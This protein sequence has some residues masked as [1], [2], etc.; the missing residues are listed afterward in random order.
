MEEKPRF[1]AVD[2]AIRRRGTYIVFLTRL[3]PLFPFPLLNY[4]FGA[5]QIKFYQY[6]IGTV[7][8]AMPATIGYTYLGTLMRNVAELWT[9]ASTN[10]KWYLWLIGG[11]IT[12]ISIVVISFIT[13]RE[14]SRATK[15]YSEQVD[16]MDEA[17]MKLIN[18]PSSVDSV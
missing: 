8:G 15:E 2:W 1:K 18:Q 4:A 12:L 6:M 16:S 11:I 3:S 9:T 5:T 7:F 17:E 13:H 10:S 14:I